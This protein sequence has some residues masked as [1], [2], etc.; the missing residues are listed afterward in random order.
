[1]TR[2]LGVEWGRFGISVVNFAPGW[3]ET[4]LN[5]TFLAAEENRRRI[6]KGIPVGRLGSAEEIGR[7]VAAVLGAKCGF[8]TG[9]TIT[10]D[11]GQ[12]VR[13]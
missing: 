8:L 1:V 13:L 3:I 6:T 5:A 10:I 4:P 7:L 12:G 9:E 11:G 2:T